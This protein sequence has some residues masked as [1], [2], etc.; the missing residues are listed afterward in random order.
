MNRL[1]RIEEIKNAHQRYVDW[2]LPIDVAGGSFLAPASLERFCRFLLV[3]NDTD[4]F[5]RW[6]PD[7]TSTEDKYYMK[8]CMLD[9]VLLKRYDKK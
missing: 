7:Y 1:E 4:W 9:S 5:D 8:S 2:W 3:A 6:L